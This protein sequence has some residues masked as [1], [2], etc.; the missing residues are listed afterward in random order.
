M[1]CETKSKLEEVVN[2][3]LEKL[4]TVDVNTKE[5]SILVKSTNDM[6]DRLIADTK[7]VMEIGHRRNQLEAETEQKAAE[8][9]QKDKNEKRN[10]FIKC[11]EIGV[12]LAVGVAACINKSRNTDKILKYEETG[13]ITSSAG[14]HVI[15]DVFRK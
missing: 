9:E 7:S 13:M 2:R 1:T 14:K 8:L 11:V 4:S 3:N 15:S 6:I 10:R 5:Y 12:T